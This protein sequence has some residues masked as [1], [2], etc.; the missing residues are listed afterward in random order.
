MAQQDALFSRRLL[1]T[2]EVDVYFDIIQKLDAELGEKQ[3][4]D[5]MQIMQKLFSVN[6]FLLKD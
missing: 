1:S 5:L 3:A 4:P 2:A 6:P